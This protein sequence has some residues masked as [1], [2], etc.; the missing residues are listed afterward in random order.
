[1]GTLTGIAHELGEFLT[2][3]RSELEATAITERERQVLELAADGLS[4]P[5]I[6]KRLFVSQATVNK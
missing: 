3:H 1:L 2:H 6:A 4:G 5:E